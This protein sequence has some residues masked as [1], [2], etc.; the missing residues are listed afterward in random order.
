MARPRI[1]LLV[2]LLALWGLLSALAAWQVQRSAVA[3]ITAILK[4]E[5]PTRID[6]AGIN[7]LGGTEV[8]GIL[9]DHL[10][11]DLAWLPT[12]GIYG[13]GCRGTVLGLDDQALVPGPVPGERV[14]LLWNTASSARHLDISLDCDIRTGRL[15]MVQLLL[16]LLVVGVI[17]TLPRPLSRSQ[18][19]CVERLRAAGLGKDESRRLSTDTRVQALSGT[20]LSWLARQ[21]RHAP[22]IEQALAVAQA[23]PDLV[24]HPERAQVSVHG[25]IIPLSATPFLYYYW[26]A[27][28]RTGQ[29]EGDDLSGTAESARGEGWFSNPPSNRPDRRNSAALIALME[30]LGG[31]RK[32]INDLA[33][34]GIRART[35]D[36]NRSKIKDE[37]VA[38]LG[39]ELAAPYLFDMKR[40]PST[41]RYLY[42]LSLSPSHIR[43][44]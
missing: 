25:V 11:R 31:H 30:R 27:M 1:L 13:A 39:E 14:T 10:N 26:Y 6:A 29:V 7:S 19:E 12:R 33:E 35:L 9:R 42:R 3:G 44:N 20:S 34:K 24:F 5:L 18:G 17:A 32:A 28:C 41:A 43:L 21:Y 2:A 37:L 22:N 8:T 15:A 23:A 40:E 38:V 4:Q 16:A 36:Q